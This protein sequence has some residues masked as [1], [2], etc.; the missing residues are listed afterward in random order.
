MS[1]EKVM[2]MRNSRATLVTEARAVLDA[3]EAEKRELNAEERQKY[4]TIVGDINTLKESIEREEKQLALENEVRDLPGKPGAMPPQE[5]PEERTGKAFKRYLLTGSEKEYRDLAN[6]IGVEGGYLHAPEYYVAQLLKGLDDLVF[7]RQFATTIPLRQNDT[8]GVP[9]LAEDMSDPTWTTEVA[10]V[11]RDT[12]MKLGKRK[13]TPNQLSKEILVSMKLLNT[14]AIPADTLVQER[15]A[16]RFAT[17]LENAFLNGSGTGEPLGVFTA[18]PDGI[19][20][21][22]DVSNGNTATEITADGLINAKYALKQQYRSRN[23]VRWAF[24]RDAVSMIAKLK[25]NDGQYIWRPGLVS[26]E[27]DKLLNIPIDE[28]EYV[29]N[30][31]TTGLYVGILADWTYYWIAEIHDLEIQRLLELYAKTSQVGFI[32]R[33]YWDGQPVMP[34]AF[35]R[36]TLA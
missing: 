8:L 29:P 18:S 35:A 22:R 19:P 14:A 23:T 30:T 2:E 13:L 20:T 12:Q 17:T 24:H 36:V 1:F 9:T 31:F 27:P 25:D 28:S 34:S 21:T 3:A 15:M 4:E 33:G 11:V 5:T 7:V 32:G 16:Y 26:G 10:S 6:D